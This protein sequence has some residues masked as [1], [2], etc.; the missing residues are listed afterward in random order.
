MH[1]AS[2]EELAGKKAENGAPMLGAI[3]VVIHEESDVHEARDAAITSVVGLTQVI[4]Q[5]AAEEKK[6]REKLKNSSDS[7]YKERQERC[8]DMAKHVTREKQ[9][10]ARIVELEGHNE[11]LRVALAKARPTEQ[12]SKKRKKG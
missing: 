3:S 12:K 11:T 5:M 10:Q 2:E 8:D 6:L 1:T 7:F 9:L 4:Q